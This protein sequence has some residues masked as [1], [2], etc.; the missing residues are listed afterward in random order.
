MTALYSLQGS[1]LE[2][3]RATTYEPSGEVPLLQ[4]TIKHQG[5]TKHYRSAMFQDLTWPLGQRI[6]RLLYQWHPVHEKGPKTCT[7][8]AK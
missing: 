4:A 6:L 8:L 1:G 5:T 2:K 7:A 3:S